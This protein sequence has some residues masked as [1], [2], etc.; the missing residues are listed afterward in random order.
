MKICYIGSSIDSKNGWGRYASD[1]IY[2]IEASECKVSRVAVQGGAR[3]FID[4]V[5]RARKLIKECD[6]V[7]ALDVYPYGVITY[8]AKVFSGKKFIISAQGTYAIEP[9]YMAKTAFLARL[10][11]RSADVIIAISNFTKGE[12]LKK[13]QL[14]NINVI[15]HGVNLEKFY[16]ERM[17]SLEDFILS[18]GALK[19]RKGYHISIPAFALVKKYF[20]KLVYKVVGSQ[21]DII[22]FNELKNIAEN[23]GVSK[24]VK[25]ICGL[26]DNELVDLYRK[27][28]L[29]LLTSVNI[30]HNF[31][32]FGFVFLEAAAAG[33]PVVGT[34]GNGIEDAVRNGANGI[35]APQGDI[36]NT[37][38][39]LMKIL[40]D[41][42]RWQGMSRASYVWA[43]EHKLEDVI[44]KYLKVYEE[45]L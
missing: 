9:L 4:A 38:D 31:E 15:N 27:A 40:G 34:L 24:D 36:R 17:P 21:E 39:A 8:L 3:G 29:F 23:Y 13:T 2:G 5:F 18:V 41:K 12:L 6:I 26:S 1:L 33:L 42:N 45:I 35:L 30:G 32:G 44:E 16:R 22:Y 14:E 37:A 20:P 11:Y 43:K 28:K 10:A 25:F 7:H 19:R